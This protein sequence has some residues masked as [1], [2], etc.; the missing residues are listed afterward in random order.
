ML[1]LVALSLAGCQKPLQGR[2]TALPTQLPTASITPTPSQTPTQLPTVTMTPTATAT[3]TDTPVPVVKYPY[4]NIVAVLKDSTV[5]VEGDNFP[6]NTD[7]TV[8]MGKMWTLGIN[9]IEVGTFNSGEGG[10]LAATFNVP[11]EMAGQSRIAV[12]LQAKTGGWFAYN[13]FWNNTVGN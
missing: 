2:P 11:P 13:W 10:K 12:R 8:L 4:F 5:S 3:P 7:F 9:G 6:A 1:V